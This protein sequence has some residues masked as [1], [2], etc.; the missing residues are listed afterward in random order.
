MHEGGCKCLHS[1]CKQSMTHWQG[2]DRTWGQ[3]AQLEDAA[4]TTLNLMPACA[5]LDPTCWGRNADR[6]LK[7]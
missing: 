1:M 3:Q 4:S 6:S 7:A 5:A 2:R